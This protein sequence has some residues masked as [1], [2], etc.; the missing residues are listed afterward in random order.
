MHLPSLRKLDTKPG[1]PPVQSLQ[2]HTSSPARTNAP[3][4]A[5]GTSP[6][7]RQVHYIHVSK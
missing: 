7:R 2:E 1:G 3:L 4:V 6:E 5:A